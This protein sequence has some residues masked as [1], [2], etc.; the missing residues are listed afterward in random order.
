M[1]NKKILW[2]MLVL[3][4]TFSLAVIGCPNETD[5]NNG[6]GDSALNGTWV[7]GSGSGSNQQEIKL[8]NGNLEVS[9]GGSSGMKGTY[10]AASGK[11]TMKVTHIHGGMFGSSASQMGLE[12]KWYSKDELKSAV[13]QVM[14]T[15]TDEQFNQQFGNMFIE[16]IGDYSVSGDTLTITTEG[17]T[18]TYTRKK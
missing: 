15:M 4:L 6:G 16:Q 7:S 9:I 2:G 8:D 11:L 1:A 13:K 18:Q 10:T 12:S 17:S 14:S 5:D 3:A